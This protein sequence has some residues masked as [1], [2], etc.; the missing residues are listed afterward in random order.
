MPVGEGRHRFP[1]FDRHRPAATGPGGGPLHHR[2]EVDV[3]AIA[4]DRIMQQMG[5]LADPELNRLGIGQSVQ[6]LDRHDA[7]KRAGPGI[8]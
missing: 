8:A 4:A 1:R 2:E 7:A 3:P 6:S 5:I